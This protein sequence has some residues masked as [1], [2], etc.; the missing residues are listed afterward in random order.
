MLYEGFLRLTDV[1]FIFKFILQINDLRQVKIKKKRSKV[2]V[3]KFEVKDEK[4]RVKVKLW[5]EATNQLTGISVGD[6]VKVLNVKISRYYDV[7]LNSTGFTRIIK[8]SVI[9][10][11]FN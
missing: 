4:D 3:L 10:S 5:E 9:S 7:S 6:V 8:V 1:L 11:L 2:A